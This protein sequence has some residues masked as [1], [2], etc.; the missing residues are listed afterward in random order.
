[1]VFAKS[2]LEY[3]FMNIHKYIN[4]I[5]PIPSIASI[6]L[7]LSI[8]ISVSIHFTRFWQRSLRVQLFIITIITLVFC[9]FI[10]I[11]IFH[12][13]R[14]RLVG[15]SNSITLTWVMISILL[16]RV[17]IGIIPITAQ[18]PPIDQNHML[19]IVA[20]G[21]KHTNSQSSSVKLVEIK[22]SN[23]RRLP[24]SAIEQD[25]NWLDK[26]GIL[27]SD[28]QPASLAYEF[29]QDDEFDILFI[30]GPENGIVSIYLDEQEIRQV[31]LFKKRS[32]T[33]GFTLVHISTSMIPQI[34]W[35]DSLKRHLL[36]IIIFSAD[37]LT[38]ASIIFLS[39]FWLVL[40]WLVRPAST[41]LKRASEKINSLLQIFDRPRGF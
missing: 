35:S 16:G 21:E 24:F 8:A 4:Q 27:V 14:R 10:Y 38:L 19:K 15:I 1:M 11:I 36:K 22:K 29:E 33:S 13:T 28:E 25:G 40:F 5:K 34:F 9:I 7:A 6:I 30:Q 41:I 39:G 26:N 3:L 23:G 12:F 32:S 17:M 2:S 31:D 37:T 18:L 20:S